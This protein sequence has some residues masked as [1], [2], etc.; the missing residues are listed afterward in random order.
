MPSEAL[1][2][3]MSASAP[4]HI[5]RSRSRSAPGHAGLDQD[6]REAVERRQLKNASG[7][8]LVCVPKGL[9]RRGRIALG[10]GFAGA[11]RR[12]MSSLGR[13]ELPC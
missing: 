3:P 11:G 6:F 8:H 12:D 4:S 7:H 10:A 2:A 5:G 13:W 9:G 1:G